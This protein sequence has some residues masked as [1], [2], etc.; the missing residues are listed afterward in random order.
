MTA[1][2]D[3][4]QF[5]SRLFS[6]QKLAHAR[7]REDSRRL[8]LEHLEP[9]QLLATVSLQ[10]GDWHDPSV[11]D[12]G[13]P[14]STQ[15]AIISS[16]TTVTL[17]GTDH[18]ADEIVVQGLLSVREDSNPS[19]KTLTTDWIH[20]N[21][22][23]EFRIGSATNRFDTNEFQLTLTGTDQQADHT[24]ETASGFMQ[25]NDNDGFLMTASGGRLNFHGDEKLA[26]TRL[27]ETADPNDNVLLV[28]NVIERN[29]DGVTSAVSDG[30]LDW[31][32]GDQIVI[33]SSSYDY[34]DEEVR[35]I[36]SIVDLG[37][38]SELILDAPLAH[39]HYGEIE[40]Y[41][42]DT[43]TWDID[44]RA[45]VVLLNRN[46]VIQGTQDTDLE[47]G[48]RAAYGTGAGENLGV[49]GHT[50]FM[51]GSGTITID[52][53][54]FDRMGQTGTLGRYPVHWHLAG[55]RVGD[56]LRNSSITNSNNRGVTVHGTQGVVME[57]NVLHDIHGHGIFMEDAAEFGN[58]F[59]FNIVLG[60]HRVGGGGTQDFTSEDPFVV[61]GITRGSDGKVN[62]QAP[63]G[64]N[65]ESSHDTGRNIANRFQHSAAFWIT[66]PDNTWIGNVSAGSEGTGFWFALP[67]SVLGLSKD[68]GF[69]D[70]M[71]P[72]Q[73]NLDQFDFNSS[74]SAPIGLTFDRGGD[75]LP[76][77]TTNSY[78]PSQKMRVNGFT[79]YK[80]M[81]TAVYH[82]ATFGVFSESRFADN[83]TS[84]FNTFNQEEQGILFVGHSRGNADPT[85]LVAGY[86]FYDG[87]GKIINSHFAGFAAENAHHFIVEGG[88]NKHSMTTAQG[89]SFEN[90][91]T[92]ETISIFHLDKADLAVNQNPVFVAGRPDSFSAVILDLDGSL[93]GHG[94]GGPGYVLTPKLDFYRDSDDIVPTGWN[95]YISNDRYAQLKIGVVDNNNLEAQHLGG[96]QG[97]YIPEFRISNS[98]SHSILVNQW[99]NTYVQRMYAKLNAGDYKIEFTHQVPQ[100]GFDLFL[101]IRNQR[102]SGDATVIQ[103]PEI[104]RYYKPSIGNEVTS[105]SA[106]RLAGQTSF[107]RSLQGDLWIKLI[108]GGL[109]DAIT[110][111][112]DPIAP[113]TVTH[114]DDSGAGSL[115]QAIAMA[116]ANPGLDVIEFAIEGG[117]Q[118]QT[119]SPL[120]PLPAITE[121]VIMD[122]ATQSRLSILDSSFENL[123]LEPNSYAIFN[124]VGDVP[125]SAWSY[126]GKVGFT[127]NI[128]S[129]QDGRIPAPVGEQH[130]LIQGSGFIGQTVSGFEVGRAYQLDLL[131]MARQFASKG[132]NLVVKLDVGEPNEI[133]LIDIP[134]ITFE[135]FT[136]I[137]SPSFIAQKSTYSIVIYANR[138]DGILTGSRTTFFDD[139]RIRRVEGVD[140]PNMIVIDGALLSSGSGLIVEAP[141]MIRALTIGNFSQGAGVLIDGAKG[142]T[143]Q[144]LWLGTDWLGQAAMPNLYG[145]EMRSDGNVVRDSLISGNIDDGIRIAGSTGNAVIFNRI[146]TDAFTDQ[147]IP[148]GNNGV[149]IVDAS[150]S[151][152][153]FNYIGNN[154][155][156]GVAV[157]GNTSSGNAIRI[158]SIQHN[159]GLGIDLGGDGVTDNDRLD[160]DAGPN[161]YSNFPWISSVT[162]GGLYNATVRGGMRGLPNTQY[163][164]DIYSNDK[165][166]PAAHGQG[167]TYVT[168]ITVLTNSKGEA[169]FQVQA[170]ITR[171]LFVSAMATQVGVNHSSEFSASVQVVPAEPNS[172]KSSHGHHLPAHR[173]IS[174]IRTQPS[175]MTPRGL[176]NETESAG[177]RPGDQ[178]LEEP[179]AVTG[180]WNRDLAIVD[181]AF[182]SPQT[183]LS[184]FE[185]E[186]SNDFY[187]EIP[188]DAEWPGSLEH[189]EREGDLGVRVGRR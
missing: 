112:V 35:T 163:V 135:E 52:S 11:W 146:G 37:T 100:D 8:S 140:V 16:G 176:M 147:A 124:G 73:T 156:N 79:A 111:P 46:I 141:S 158:N 53:V 43:R 117:G 129:L 159:L 22:G 123:T 177:S 26:F 96:I 56:V 184:R 33:A 82:R 34:N 154:R 173:A 58:Q 32:V 155:N 99:N 39:R 153:L 67:K 18:V 189:H 76:G 1:I 62:G 183:S 148:N 168:Q 57:S 131:T 149:G 31:A 78:E 14:D 166:A 51:P 74:H 127:R 86:R 2:P 88:A 72:L 143:A 137:V 151:A 66:N 59:L 109:S 89:I 15:R 138:N 116:N 106:L 94:G 110:I 145:V 20:I 50:M 130:A 102:Q 81:G 49:G 29:F 122:G 157:L 181:A 136:R 105:V 10:S 30:S 121:R 44:L 139:V 93:T 174:S 126:L 85:A 68:S 12:N 87:P 119:I 7:S 165:Q 47:F 185:E 9:R 25:V 91:G 128:S 97:E 118:V 160:Q 162:T 54:Q 104:G 80:H 84:S 70:D 75:L 103:F 23:G 125:G 71:N 60:I 132:N 172:R 38:T 161:Q 133:T 6:A 27:A 186:L 152:V 113:W 182:H 108:A 187:L 45:E 101:Q 179:V 92:A 63:R 178:V 115:R 167:Q 170:S 3:W 180:R 144:N 107:Y 40:T 171:G 28:N 24:I 90:D 142:T 120:T 19:V 13:I 41:R 114:T 42:S 83:S 5:L 61:P 150:N 69:Y 188:A 164:I 175:G 65:G 48:D 169:R 36:T 4:K 134:E 21:S 77:A 98:S 64:E 17:S 55:N 95:A